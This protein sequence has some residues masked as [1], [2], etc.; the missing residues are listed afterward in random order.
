VGQWVF[1]KKLFCL[2][3]VNLMDK[4]RHC[5]NKNR[6]HSWRE[7]KSE[8]GDSGGSRITREKPQFLWSENPKQ[9]GI[10]C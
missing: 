4:K 7:I 6:V 8:K 10:P 9:G 5:L 1:S 3:K 2:E